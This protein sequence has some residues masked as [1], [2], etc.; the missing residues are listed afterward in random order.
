MV[1]EQLAALD[2]S[3][4]LLVNQGLSNPILDLLL[5]TV[6][7]LGSIIFWLLIFFAAIFKKEKKLYVPMFFAF[8]INVIFLTILK[9]FIGRPRPY[10]TLDGVNTLDTENTGGFPSGHASNAFLGATLLADIYKKFAAPLYI[11]AVVVAF[12][13][14][15]VGM[16][17]PTDVLAGAIEGFV[18]AK[19]ILQ[20]KFIQ[21]F[22]K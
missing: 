18:L 3:V 9:D 19:L 4:F 21:K 16:H 5:S 8:L 14:I 20:W 15:Y 12:S 11:L 7:H 22:Q 6:T 17:Y 2:T 13:R 10:E 1:L